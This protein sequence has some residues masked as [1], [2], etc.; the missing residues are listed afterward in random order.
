MITD[1]CRSDLIA[2]KLLSLV[3]NEGEAQ[4][5]IDEIQSTLKILT[6][7][8]GSPSEVSA[9]VVLSVLNEKGENKNE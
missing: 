4:T 6:P 9:K 1:K 7:L 2:D 3:Q 5:Q 8:E